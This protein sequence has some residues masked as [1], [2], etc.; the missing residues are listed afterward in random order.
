MTKH[1]TQNQIQIQNKTQ[2]KTQNKYKKITNII[3]HSRKN[4]VI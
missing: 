4:S 3:L 1:K 2:N